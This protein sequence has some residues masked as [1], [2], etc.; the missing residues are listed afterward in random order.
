[1]KNGLVVHFNPLHIFLN[2]A[3]FH[4]HFKQ[5][6]NYPKVCTSML[7]MSTFLRASFQMLYS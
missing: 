5:L 4:L 2:I 1:M 7:L 6:P 3:Y